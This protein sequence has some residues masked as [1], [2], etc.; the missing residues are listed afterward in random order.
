MAALT[1]ITLASGASADTGTFLTMDGVTGAAGTANTKVQ[2]VQGIASM[3]ALKV[4]G[5]AVTQPVSGTVTAN[6]GSGTLAVSLASVP[7]HAVTNAGTFAVQS[8]A[9]LAAETTK[10]IGVVRTADGAGNL[11]TSTSN[12]LDVNIKSLSGGNS[13]GQATMANSAPVV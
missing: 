8:A 5:S 6:A 3:T 11:L 7:S 13:N 2:T 4:D 1:Q 12:A 9:T 10:V